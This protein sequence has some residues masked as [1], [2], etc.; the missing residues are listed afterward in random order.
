MNAKIVVENRSTLISH[1][2][3]GQMV[4]GVRRQLAHDYSEAWGSRVMGF[5]LV[6]ALG[7]AP[8]AWPIVI[9]DDADQADALGYH[10]VTPDGRPYGRVF[11][12]D[13]LD[14]G[15]SVLAGPSAVSVTLS[16]EALEM[17]R[18]PFASFWA[19]DA[20]GGRLVALELCDAVEADAYP[21]EVPDDDHAHGHIS[22][23]VSNFVLPAFFRP[24]PGPYDWLRLCSRPFE[25]RPG[26][27]Q[28]VQKEEEM[29][30]EYDSIAPW[31]VRA[32]M[33]KASRT[34]RRRLA[35]GCN[36]AYWP[37]KGD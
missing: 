35:Y 5:E 17:A 29:L 24:G 6:S 19:D 4:L 8:N 20:E 2:Q 26:G 10:A 33:H 31:R 1:K 9:L 21:V 12:R 28:L 30:A 15:G 23:W 11:V 27:Y 34:Y 3:A 14:N 16:H 7:D 36:P 22:V 25:T 32:K 18:D 13:T 37:P